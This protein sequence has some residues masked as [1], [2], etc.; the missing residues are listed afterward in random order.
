MIIELHPRFKKH[1][2]KRIAH[3]IKLIKQTR[4]RITLF[5]N[6]PH[7]PLLKNHSLLGKRT[8]LRAFSITG[9]IRTVYFPISKNRVLFLDIGTH[10]Q[11]Y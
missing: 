11:V 3:N 8:H 6:N 10:N 1:Y 4:E 5:K 2:K 9:D 7:Y